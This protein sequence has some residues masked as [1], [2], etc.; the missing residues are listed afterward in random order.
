MPTSVSWGI[1]SCFFTLQKSINQTMLKI[2]VIENWFSL[3]IN[4][5]NFSVVDNCLGLQT[6]SFMAPK[7]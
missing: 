3:Q 1:H 6:E 5:K 7:S 4:E 2:V